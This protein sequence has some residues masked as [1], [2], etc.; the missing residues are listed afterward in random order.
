MIFLYDFKRP[1]NP[2]VPVLL[3]GDL[4]VEKFNPHGL[5]VYQD[6]TSSKKIVL[7]KNW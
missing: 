4:D 7:L 1:E 3:E 5:S 2:A 6:Q